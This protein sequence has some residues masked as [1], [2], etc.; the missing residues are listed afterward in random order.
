MEELTC[1]VPHNNETFNA[2]RVTWYHEEQPSKRNSEII[3]FLLLLRLAGSH[4]R[5]RR[6]EEGATE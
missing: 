1:A 4:G 6:G 3:S 2:L 5:W